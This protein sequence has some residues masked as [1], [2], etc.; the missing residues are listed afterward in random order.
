MEEMGQEQCSLNDFRIY[1]EGEERTIT[2]FQAPECQDKMLEKW[3]QK[4]S[5][6]KLNARHMRAYY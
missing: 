2:E 1:P 4:H 6:E 3:F 5:G